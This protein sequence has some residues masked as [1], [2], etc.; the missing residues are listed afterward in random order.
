MRLGGARKDGGNSS[1]NR[2]RRPMWGSGSWAK[3]R[4]TASRAHAG[5][6]M[7][8]LRNGGYRGTGWHRGDSAASGQHSG[9]ETNIGT[10]PERTRPQRGGVSE[11]STVGGVATPRRGS[12]VARLPAKGTPWARLPSA[13]CTRMGSGVAQDDAK[14]RKWYGKAADQGH[15]RGYRA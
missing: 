8:R 2:S 7:P 4:D 14:A 15:A 6:T 3:R 12:G 9:Q 11:T 1:A 5:Q 10:P 13:P